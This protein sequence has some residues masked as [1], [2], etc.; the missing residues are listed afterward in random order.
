MNNL[1]P[2]AALRPLHAPPA[3]SW[4]PPAPG[5][6]LLLLIGLLAI[7]LGFWWWWRNAPQRAALRELDRLN[8]RVSDPMRLAAAINRLL[9]RYA[10]L[11]WPRRATA[12][13]SGEAWLAFLDA[14]GGQGAF[15]QGPGRR[16]LDQPYASA[17]SADLSS[18]PEQATFVQVVRRWIKTNRPGMRK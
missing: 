5:W 12:A 4:W 16:L 13:L 18:D 9:K 1:D 10:L 3:I 8:A 2:L 17:T 7:L 11:C 6:W 15:R 14:H